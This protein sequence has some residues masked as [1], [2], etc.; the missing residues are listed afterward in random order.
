ML[1]ISEVLQ[2]WEEMKDSFDNMTEGG[3]PNISEGDLKTLKK[4]KILLQA[5]LD[6]GSIGM[7]TT[8]KHDPLMSPSLSST[9]ST[10]LTSLTSPISTP[11][12]QRT[13][14]KWS[15]TSKGTPKIPQADTGNV[16][17]SSQEVTGEKK[18]ENS[19][20]KKPTKGQIEIMSLPAHTDPPIEL[21]PTQEGDGNNKEIFSYLTGIGEILWFDKKSG[22][23]DMIICKP[24]DFIQSLGN[25][26]T[27]KL[28]R[29]CTA[30]KFMHARRDI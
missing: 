2:R 1:S 24:M 12:T 21:A 18:R 10:S 20:S 27:H 6:E 30:T 19:G 22:I 4:F 5:K 8:G 14:S 7:S 23:K 15:R 26:I 16:K 29:N 13:S 11:G 17:V 25:I 28:T 3:V 9:C